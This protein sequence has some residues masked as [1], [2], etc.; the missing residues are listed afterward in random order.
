M[1][2]YAV[3]K[4]MSVSVGG[5][6]QTICRHLIAFSLPK[7]NRRSERI[8]KSKIPKFTIRIIQRSKFLGDFQKTF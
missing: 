5:V 7:H 4:L 3:I 8:E 1:R 2:G 6:L